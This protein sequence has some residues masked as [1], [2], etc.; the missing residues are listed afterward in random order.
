MKFTISSEGYPYDE[1]LAVKDYVIVH[2]PLG[3]SWSDGAWCGNNFE[4]RAE[5]QQAAIDD[6]AKKKERGEFDYS[7]SETIRDY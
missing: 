4:T 6:Y 3:Y 1:K 5:A 2:T 7:D